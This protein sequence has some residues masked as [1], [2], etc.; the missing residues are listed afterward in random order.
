MAGLSIDDVMDGAVEAAY[1]ALVRLIDDTTYLGSMVDARQVANQ[2]AARAFELAVAYNADRNP[3][4]E[5]SLP[6]GDG[7][8]IA[9]E[10]V[11]LDEIVA[12][13]DAR[14]WCYEIDNFHVNS[15]LAEDSAYDVRTWE[16]IAGADIGINIYAA[17]PDDGSFTQIAN[18]YGHGTLG[19]ALKDA[20]EVAV[21]SGL[22]S[23]ASN[24][25]RV[26]TSIAPPWHCPFCGNMVIDGDGHPIDC[27]REG[28]G[29]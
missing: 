12:D 20:Y 4:S 27:G 25:G 5:A 19:E 15:R 7:A 6:A 2:I 17:N 8:G 10:V 28:E 23:E 18:V 21:E 16:T 9:G 24:A 22:P 1:D 26:G 3:E 14:G 13:I 11:S 29:T